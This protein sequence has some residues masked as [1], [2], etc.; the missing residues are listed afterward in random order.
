MA[1]VGVYLEL[2][3]FG[4]AVPWMSGWVAVLHFW[5]FTLHF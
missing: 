4:A 1:E 3:M 2:L 5:R